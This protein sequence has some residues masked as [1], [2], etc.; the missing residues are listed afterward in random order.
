MIQLLKKLLLLLHFQGLFGRDGLRLLEPTGFSVVLEGI[1]AG[2]WLPVVI[3]G[4]TIDS[5]LVFAYLSKDLG[6]FWLHPSLFGPLRIAFA[7]WNH[8]KA[9]SDIGT[10]ARLVITLVA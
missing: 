6:T 9:C 1:N 5:L 3:L 2:A 10:T 8:F 7:A 4:C